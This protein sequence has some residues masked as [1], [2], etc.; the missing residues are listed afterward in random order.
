MRRTSPP[1]APDWTDHNASDPG[2]TLLQ[3]LVYALAA[4]AAGRAVVAVWW[5]RTRAD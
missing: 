3:L 1:P 2:V 5:R 4:F